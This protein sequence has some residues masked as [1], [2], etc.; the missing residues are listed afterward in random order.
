VSLLAPIL[1]L[2]LFKLKA[3]LAISSIAHSVRT[4]V[5]PSVPKRPIASSTNDDDDDDDDCDDV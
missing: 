4:K 3:Y 1:P 5:T 2:E